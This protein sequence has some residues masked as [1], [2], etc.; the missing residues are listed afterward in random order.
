[1]TGGSQENSRSKVRAASPCPDSSA[2]LTP[3][4]LQRGDAQARDNQAD[5]QHRD[6]RLGQL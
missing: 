6:L 2:C 5:P 3:P 4:E 1:M